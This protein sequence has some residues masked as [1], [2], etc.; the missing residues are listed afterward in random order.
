MDKQKMALWLEHVEEIISILEDS[1]IGE[2]ELTEAGTEIIIRRKP[3]VVTVSTPTDHESIS[4]AGSPR[5]LDTGRLHSGDEGVAIVSP[6]TGVYYAA[7][8]PSEPPFVSLNDIVHAGQAVALIEAMKVFNEV[9]SEVSGR[10]IAI[11]ATSG[12]VVQKGDAL[13]RIQPL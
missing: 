6:L 1:T 10:V 13:L 5:P 8:S 9:H 7:P 3:G 2:L 4:Y 11:T 12:N